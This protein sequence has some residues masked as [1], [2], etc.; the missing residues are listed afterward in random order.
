[1]SQ[2]SSSLSRLLL[3]QQGPAIIPAR[4]LEAGL[5][6]VVGIQGRFTVELIDAATGQVKRRLEFKNLITNV[7]LNAVMNNVV[8][9]LGQL[10]YVAVGTGST[11][12]AAVQTTLVAELA[13]AA[14]PRTSANGGFAD[15]TG[16]DSA[17]GYGKFIRT[18]LYTEAQANGNL[19][20]LGMFSAST[21]GTMWTRQL[22]L[23][24]GGNPTVVTKTS[25]DQLK[26]IYELRFYH[27][28]ADV[29]G[30]IAVNGINYT[31]A[32]RVLNRGSGLAWATRIVNQFFGGNVWEGEAY[33]VNVLA[34]DTAS[35]V[36][37]ATNTA[38]TGYVAA[39]YVADSFVRD[40]TLKVE[41][42]VGNFAGGVG[43]HSISASGVRLWQTTF[44][45]KL[46]KDSSKRLT[47]VNR[48]GMA[49]V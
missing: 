18:R 10:A 28:I 3:S 24:G 31:W 43:G 49:R 12:P 29:G 40:M 33:D 30:V 21:A 5:E 22:F 48:M 16:A 15:E 35:F 4:A 46:P 27:P 34:A 26:I 8:S 38:M 41:P 19:T 13:S 2:P 20:E 25:A 44:T 6:S 45:P 1:M 42:A 37:G 39:A 9:I 36:S 17:A 23:D 11:A 7:G 32:R 14:V 47:F